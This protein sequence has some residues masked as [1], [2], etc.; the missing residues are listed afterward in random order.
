MIEEANPSLKERLYE[1][2]KES[3]ELVYILAAIVKSATGKSK[4]GSMQNAKT[5]TKV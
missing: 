2:H 1:L 3:K 4:K 5:I